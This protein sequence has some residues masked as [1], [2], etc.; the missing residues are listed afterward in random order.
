MTLVSAGNCGHFARGRLLLDRTRPMQSCSMESSHPREAAT[1]RRTCGNSRRRHG[2]N[3]PLKENL[4]PRSRSP[5]EETDVR[6][7][8]RSPSVSS[9][10]FQM[11]PETNVCT[12]SGN[13]GLSNKQQRREKSLWAIANVYVVRQPVSTK[14]PKTRATNTDG[15]TTKGHTSTNSLLRQQHARET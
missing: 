6:P 15:S 2:S 3:P 4:A 10:K 12:H 11:F 1:G 14:I 5:L 13:E 9:T 8:H 7:G